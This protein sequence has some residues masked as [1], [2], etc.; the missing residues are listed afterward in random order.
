MENQSIHLQNIALHS[1]ICYF[2]YC[3]YALSYQ[4]VKLQQPT[5]SQF[6]Y[7]R[8]EVN[9]LPKR[10]PDFQSMCLEYV[11]T[12]ISSF[13]QPITHTHTHTH[14]HMHV[15]THTRVRR[16]R[17]RR[18]LQQTYSLALLK[19]QYLACFHANRF[20]WWETKIRSQ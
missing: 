4:M 16:R 7:I 5:Q 14:T 6:K 20:G 19:D 15:H 3:G 9:A 17:R 10:S 1:E 13:Y 2:T 18:E 8:Q 12:R 11:Y